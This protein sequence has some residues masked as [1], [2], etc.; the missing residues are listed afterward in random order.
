MRLDVCLVENGFFP[1]R[2]KAREAIDEGRVI[3]GGKILKA[4]FEVD[5]LDGI[6]IIP[7]ESKFV[8]NG[9]YKLEKGIKDFNLSIDGMT[10]IDV[11]ASNGGFT[12]CLLFN[13]ASFVYAL[14]VGE[15]QLDIS[16]KNDKRVKVI[17]NYNARNLNLKVLDNREM[18]GATCD[19]SFISLKYVLKPIYDI[20]KDDGI[21]ISLIKPQFECGKSALDKNGIVKDKRDHFEAVAS[22]YD[23]AVNIGYS[24]LDFTNAP[25][26]EKKNVEYL[27]LLKKGRGENITKEKIKEIIFN[28]G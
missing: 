10:F 28:R 3:K 14:D 7:L 25:I 23:F 17:D 18:D 21:L 24:I 16:L 9:G 19:V 8:S 20:L 13:G 2:N 26:K 22:L 15:S 12:D 27:F 1:S 6:E 11:G 5:N 4:S